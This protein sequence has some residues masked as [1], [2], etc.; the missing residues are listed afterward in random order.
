M[1]ILSVC[2]ILE[3]IAKA[4]YAWI[5]VRNLGVLDN[6]EKANLY[7]KQKLTR[8]VYRAWRSLIVSTKKSHE[9]LMLYQYLL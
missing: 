1:I 3:N 2:S 8:R 4:F 7:Y 6:E 5:Q 9:S